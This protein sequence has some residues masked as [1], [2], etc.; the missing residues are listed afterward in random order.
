[1]TT[2]YERTYTVSICLNRAQKHSMWSQAFISGTWSEES[3]SE[4]E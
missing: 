3:C 2:E 1:M 4:P